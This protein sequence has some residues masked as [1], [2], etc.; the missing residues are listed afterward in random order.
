MTVGR[1]TACPL[2]PKALAA[3]AAVA[4]VLPRVAAIR[5]ALLLLPVA[6]VVAAT[7]PLGVALTVEDLRPVL[8]D[9]AV[10]I[11]MVRLA[12]AEEE[13]ATTTVVALATRIAAGRALLVASTTVAAGVRV[14]RHLRWT[15]SASVTA[16]DTKTLVRPSGPPIIT[17]RRLIVC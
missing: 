15:S 5:T 10:T 1:L 6:A 7:G 14:C 3:L 17:I 4:M 16:R 9:R 12:V 11:V 8:A 13:E 2:R